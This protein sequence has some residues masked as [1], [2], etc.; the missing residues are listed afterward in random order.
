MKKQK[1]AVVI[2]ILLITALIA[3]WIYDSEY[4]YPNTE[5]GRLAAVKDY[6]LS[7]EDSMGHDL[8]IGTPVEVLAWQTLED[9][10]YIFYRADNKYNVHG[11]VELK[12][13][14]NGKYMPRK[15]E[16]DPTSRIAGVY[17]WKFASKCTD[18]DYIMLAGKYDENIAYVDIEYSVTNFYNLHQE[19]IVKRYVYTENFLDIQDYRT[20]IEDIGFQYVERISIYA[21]KT[22]IYD[23][24]GNDITAQYR[25]ESVELSWVASKSTA[26]VFVLYL[27]M[28]FVIFFGLLIA[29]FAWKEWK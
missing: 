21:D 6:V 2:I 7:A 4:H 15:A 22:R 9:R 16:M 17:L 11:I 14:W 26:E 13:G 28:G 1:L 3:F 18:D 12:K 8:K 24:Q 29:R 25:D 23:A 19:P 20:A 27:A 5:A 10:L